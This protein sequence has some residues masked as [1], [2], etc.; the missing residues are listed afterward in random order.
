MKI[1]NFKKDNNNKSPRRFWSIFIMMAVIIVAL[2]GLVTG[3]VIWH[4][5]P[6]FCTMCHTPMKDYVDNYF[7]GDTTLMITQHASGDSIYKCLDCHESNLGEQLREGSHWLTGNYTFPLEKREFG[8][9]SFCLTTGCHVE[10]E[11]IEAT[12]NE[13]KS[14]FSYNQHDPRHGKQDCYNCHSMHGESVFSCNQ[15]HNYELPEGWISPQP[16]GEII[17][18]QQALNTEI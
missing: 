5:Q 12:Q 13:Y 1:L 11:I 2:S 9:R 17:S 3:G 10:E 15:C 4:E 6:G 16:N 14:L 8:T 18:Q 7:A